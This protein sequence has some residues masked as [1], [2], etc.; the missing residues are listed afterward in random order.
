MTT[1]PACEQGERWAYRQNGPKPLEEIEVLKIGVKKPPRVLVRWV[2]PEAEGRE[3]WVPPGRLKCL[4]SEV[5]DLRAKESKW[6]AVVAP[7]EAMTVLERKTA[8][9]VFAETIPEAIADIA[10]SRPEG[11]GYINDEDML[12]ELLDMNVS[13]FHAHEAVYREDDRLIVPWPITEAIILRAAQKYSL[14]IK[15]YVESHE[16]K[17][18]EELL[19]GY[20]SEWEKGKPRYVSPEVLRARSWGDEERQ[21]LNQLRS[22]CG[23]ETVL[24]WDELDALRKEVVRLGELLDDTITVLARAGLAEEAERLQGRVGV[25]AATL[26]SHAREGGSPS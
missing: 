11:I 22:W 23:G 19:H 17:I 18:E 3:E 1:P 21:I 7:S 2:R 25:P 13:A 5:D 20:T 12:A 15:A 6:A 24:A 9:I 26:R 4:W 8:W 16:A 14:K 10:Y